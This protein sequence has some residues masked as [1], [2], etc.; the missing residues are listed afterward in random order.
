[1]M[2]LLIYAVALIKIIFVV[3]LNISKNLIYELMF[4]L[5]YVDI[6]GCLDLGVVVHRE[7]HIIDQF[8]YT[9][10]IHIV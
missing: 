6:F 3:R 8:S 9:F 1:M 2:F 5:I 7:N 10:A 4:L